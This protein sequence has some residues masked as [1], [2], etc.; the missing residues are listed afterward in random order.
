M[1]GA[2]VSENPFG[3]NPGDKAEFDLATADV[4]LCAPE[5]NAPV[6]YV[7]MP[8]HWTKADR[9]HSGMP[10]RH[11]QEKIRLLMGDEHLNQAAVYCAA[12]LKLAEKWPVEV[13]DALIAVVGEDDT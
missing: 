13:L 7:R 9:D 11:V 2:L 12:L 8:R 10:Y 6:G 1:G 4:P 3:P 5:S